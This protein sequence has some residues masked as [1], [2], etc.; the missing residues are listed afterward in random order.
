M[1]RR[2]NQYDEVRNKR[3]SIRLYSP[4]QSLTGKS[5]GCSWCQEGEP[6]KHITE[7]TNITINGT[8]ILR[9]VGNE[10]CVRCVNQ[11]KRDL[12][13]KRW[14]RLRLAILAEQPYCT[15]CQYRQLLIKA[16]ILDHI[17][18]WR[19]RPDLFWQGENLQPLCTDCH[20]AKS[21]A[22]RQSQ[23]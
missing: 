11:F 19:F 16:T 6:P 2:K 3:R 10:I 4:G 23:G 9:Y 8:N 22:E 1:S 20:N 18:P 5:K 12:Q 15:D 17:I 21:M 13:G 14:K 7:E